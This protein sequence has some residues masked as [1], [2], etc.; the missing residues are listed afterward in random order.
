MDPSKA[1]DIKSQDAVKVYSWITNMINA[2]EQETHLAETAAFGGIS[3]GAAVTDVV[4]A[5]HQHRANVHY[6]AT[7]INDAVNRFG[8]TKAPVWPELCN[9]LNECI[10][11]CA[12]AGDLVDSALSASAKSPP[13]M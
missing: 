13:S 2:C 5:F 4:S 3:A 7:L 9:K 6:Q 12:I 11:R 1:L 8:H 10:T